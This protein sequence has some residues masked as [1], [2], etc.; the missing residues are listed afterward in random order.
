MAVYL[1]PYVTSPSLKH[2]KYVSGPVRFRELETVY[3]KCIKHFRHD[4]LIIHKLI[5]A[6]ES[7]TLSFRK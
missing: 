4:K 2:S 7:Q 5:G 6:G 1:L 3:P